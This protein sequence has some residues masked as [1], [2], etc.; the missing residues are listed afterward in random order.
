VVRSSIGNKLFCA[1]LGVPHLQEYRT[2]KKHG[3]WNLLTSIRTFA[4]TVI[5]IKGESGFYIGVRRA[6]C[7]MSAWF[8]G[9]RGKEHK[10]VLQ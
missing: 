4:K 2:R 8:E 7:A 9:E 5:W 6:P 1:T 3:G 10:V